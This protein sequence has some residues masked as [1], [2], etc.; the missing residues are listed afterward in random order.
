[1]FKKGWQLGRSHQYVNIEMPMKEGEKKR[2]I[3][4]PEEPQDGSMGSR[5]KDGPKQ[6]GFKKIIPMGLRG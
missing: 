1:M 2:R 4:H 6:E 3:V 5:R